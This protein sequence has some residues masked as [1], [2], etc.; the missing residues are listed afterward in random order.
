MSA[1]GSVFVIS[2]AGAPVGDGKASLCDVLAQPWGEQ[3]FQA[4]LASAKP[5]TAT[6]GNDEREPSLECLADVEPKNVEYI[7][8]PR[9]PL[10]MISGIEGNPGEGKTFVC[11]SAAADG[12]RG[13]EPFTGLE[14]EKFKTVYLSNEN[15]LAAVTKPKFKAMGGDEKSF[16]ALSGAVNSDG[17]QAGITLADIP[18]FEK[19]M[20]KTHAKLLIID[21]LQSYM[22]ASVDSHKANETR[23][24]LDGLA[25]LAERLNI[26]ILIVRHLAPALTKSDPLMLA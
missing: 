13:K 17:S 14:C 1:P 15:L 18:I 10:G 7:S 2:L 20:L 9:L 3:Y 21:P 22:G 25:R 5:W 4:K 16:F 24:L 19:A 12:S 26:C 23:P 6:T 8:K 11:L